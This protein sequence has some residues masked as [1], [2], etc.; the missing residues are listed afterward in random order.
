M[1]DTKQADIK[2]ADIKQGDT[3]QSSSSISK[4]KRVIYTIFFAVVFSVTKFV[5]TALVVVQ[6]L[7]T[8]VMS[9]PNEQ[10]LKFSK[11]VTDYINQIMLF[12]TFQSNDI[13]FPL[14]PTV[15]MIETKTES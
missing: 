11:M 1:Q 5:F 10:I 14:T 3:K 13:P 8:L 4:F 12:M 2:Q 9:S 7:Y 15:K 6:V